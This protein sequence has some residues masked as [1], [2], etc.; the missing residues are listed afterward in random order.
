MRTMLPLLL[1]A[2]CRAA[3]PVA[4]SPATPVQASGLRTVVVTVD[5]ME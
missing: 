2:A 5:K 1:L 3:P 4:T